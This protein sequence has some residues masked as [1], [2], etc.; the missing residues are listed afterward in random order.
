MNAQTEEFTKNIE[1]LS[2]LQCDFV[3]MIIRNAGKRKHG[4][5]YTSDERLLCLSIY[6]RS[7]SAYRYLCSFLPLPAPRRV[8]QLLSHIRLDC[9]VTKT[10]KDCLK[11]MANRMMD[12]LD[13]VCIL[14]WDE[15]SLQLNVQYCAEKDKLVG[16]EDWG[17]NRT[18]K[19]ADHA[20]VFMLRGIKT[21]WKVPVAYNFCTAQTTHGQLIYCIKEV[22]RAVTEAG[23]IVAATV[24]DQG[25]SNMKAIKTMQQDTDKIRNQK[26]IK[27]C[28]YLF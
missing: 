16:L 1:D 2:S 19:Y 17:T 25:S 27:K 9:G 15:V 10:I 6:K 26:G 28:K 4:R 7:A 13:K 22:V 21:G 12:P 20:L 5:R 24:C 11:E 14:M 18:A 23:F 8:R 3:N